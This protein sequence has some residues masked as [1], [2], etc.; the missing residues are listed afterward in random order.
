MR[1]RHEF[2]VESSADVYQGRVMAL[3][4]DRVVMPGGR[5]A[6]REI[7]EHPGAVAIAALDPAD[8]LMMIHQY[9]HPVRR[10]LWELPAGLLD[11]AGEDPAATAARELVEEAGLAASDWSVLLDIVPSPGFSDEAVRVYLARGLTE[12]D[13]PDAGDDEEADLQLRWVPLPVAV[14]MVLDGTI[15]NA[16]A[17]AAVLAVQ[18]VCDG[19]SPR[20]VDAGWPDRPSRFAARNR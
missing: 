5:I 4:A 16:A 9:R 8:R 15:V 1:S 11:V 14:D 20:P 13:R 12:I 10:R 2:Q 6:T 17:V 7:L 19:R 18:V 3:R